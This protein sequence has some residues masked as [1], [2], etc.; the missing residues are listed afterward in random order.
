MKDSAPV[1]TGDLSSGG[2]SKYRSAWPAKLE[3]IS[4]IHFAAAKA[5]AF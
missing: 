3:S 2:A 1:R 4:T 5:V